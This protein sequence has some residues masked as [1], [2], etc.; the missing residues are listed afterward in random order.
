MGGI[1]PDEDP[2]W[3]NDTD[4]HWWKEIRAYLKAIQQ[5]IKGA[6]RKQVLRELLKEGF[7]EAQILEIEAALDEAA[8]ELGSEPPPFLP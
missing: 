5:A 8:R 2:K 7:T 6:S 4:N 1:P 3:N